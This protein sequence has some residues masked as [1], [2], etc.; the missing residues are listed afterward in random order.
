MQI[1]T[2][3]FSIVFAYLLGSISS[4]VIVSKLCDLPDPRSEGSKN[5]GAT[6][7]LR[8]SGK[9]YALIVII[10]D[11][12][13]GL[14]P[15]LVAK[16]LGLSPAIVS[17]TCFAAVFGHMYPIFFRF[18]GG[19][20]VATA[21]GGLLGLHFL[22][23]TTVIATWLVIANVFRYSSVASMLTMILTPLYSLFFLNR[24]DTFVALFMIMIFVLFKH[25]NNITRLMDGNEPKIDFSKFRKVLEQPNSVSAEANTEMEQDEDQIIDATE[26]KDTSQQSPEKKEP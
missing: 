22:L 18:H 19:K 5:P 14:I 4:A 8:L 16:L 1:A 17:Y 6:N 7:V 23:G 21:M 20:G 10:A 9:K 24:I 12:L 3:V 2:T 15:V 11:I 25:R 26:E 13:K